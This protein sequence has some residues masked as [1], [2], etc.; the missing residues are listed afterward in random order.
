LT[1]IGSRGYDINRQPTGGRCGSN[2]FNDV[3]Y[4][5]NRSLIVSL[6]RS[7]EAT[8]DKEENADKAN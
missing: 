8:F 1:P 7:K 4:S 6:D 5:L 2:S 3:G